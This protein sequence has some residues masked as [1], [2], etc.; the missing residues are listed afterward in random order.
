M[1]VSGAGQRA[2]RRRLPDPDPTLACGE[3]ET[4]HM[5]VR[6]R[7]LLPTPL[8]THEAPMREEALHIQI[9]RDCTGPRI[10]ADDDGVPVALA[11]K[12]IDLALRI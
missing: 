6:H 1:A 9:E 2:S 11:G 5:A 8:S 12:D 10:Q 7:V 4:A 3:A